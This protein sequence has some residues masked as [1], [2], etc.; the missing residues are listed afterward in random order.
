M[1]Y[2]YLI[3]RADATI[4][5]GPEP[6]SRGNLTQFELRTITITADDSDF[7]SESSNTCYN[8]NLPALTAFDFVV[9]KHQMETF[10]ESVEKERLADINEYDKCLPGNEHLEPYFEEIRERAARAPQ[11]A[12]RAT[13]QERDRQFDDLLDSIEADRLLKE[14]EA[15]TSDDN[16]INPYVEQFLYST[17]E[18]DRLFEEQQAKIDEMRKFSNIVQKQV[19]ELHF[20][21]EQ[22]RVAAEDLIRAN[23]DT[24]R[25]IAGPGKL[26]IV[27]LLI[28]A[29]L[30]TAILHDLDTDPDGRNTRVVISTA[31]LCHVGLAACAMHF[32]LPSTA[33]I[34]VSYLI[35]SVVTG[36]LTALY[37]VLWL[38]VVV[39][40]GCVPCVDNVWW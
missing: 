21:T 22:V 5:R 29:L 34:I 17:T 16:P 24:I 2:A 36:P 8:P 23:E 20:R 28:C 13:E 39:R 14:R 26:T 18:A 19:N 4:T 32:F 35:S 37:L 30:P 11:Q 7:R 1:V 10:H 38:R 12:A 33:D 3:E 27:L 31:H 40:G 9:F 25:R 6:S 15:V